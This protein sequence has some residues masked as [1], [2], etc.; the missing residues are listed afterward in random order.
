MEGGRVWEKEERRSRRR[1]KCLIFFFA[2]L[3]PP[4]SAQILS[5]FFFFF[6]LRSERDQITLASNLRPYFEWREE[7]IS[8]GGRHTRCDIAF[9]SHLN[10]PS[11]FLLFF[12]FFS[13]VSARSVEMRK[14]TANSLVPPSRTHLYS[15][16]AF[17]NRYQLPCCRKECLASERTNESLICPKGCLFPSCIF[18]MRDREMLIEIPDGNRISGGIWFLPR[19]CWVACS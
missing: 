8:K 19:S 1:L 11:L 4:I 13:F 18:K 17:L 14:W 5:L 10:F 12:S 2:S 6:L 7:G 3:L 9:S 15:C 16:Y